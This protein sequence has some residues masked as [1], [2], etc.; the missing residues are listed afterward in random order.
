VIGD[1][2]L[3]RLRALLARARGDATAYADLRDRYR[4]MAKTL[5]YEGHIEW[6]EAMPR[7]RLATAGPLGATLSHEA[8]PWWSMHAQHDTEP[9]RRDMPSAATSLGACRCATCATRQH[10]HSTVATGHSRPR[11]A[12]TLHLLPTRTPLREPPEPGRT[13]AVSPT[14]TGSAIATRLSSGLMLSQQVSVLLAIAWGWSPRRD[15]AD[16]PCKSGPLSPPKI[17]SSYANAIH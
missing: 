1:T 17:G 5:G 4:D 9:L 8:A 10:W 15:A 7:R 16:N 3:L 14:L 11:P 2:W 13:V 6:A 12:N